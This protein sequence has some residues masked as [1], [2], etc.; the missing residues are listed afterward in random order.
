MIV[1]FVYMSI[2]PRVSKNITFGM[3]LSLN[4]NLVSLW[5]RI[6]IFSLGA[7]FVP[8]FEPSRKHQPID[9][10][11]HMDLMIYAPQQI[12]LRCYYI[13]RRPYIIIM[14]TSNLT[15]TFL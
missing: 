8:T 12:T 3:N 1:L 14:N 11:L 10:R 6:I 2:K 4:S 9:I 15:L 13:L 7:I 5:G